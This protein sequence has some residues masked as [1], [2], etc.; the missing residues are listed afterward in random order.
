MEDD[1][2]SKRFVEPSIIGAIRVPVSRMCYE[3]FCVLRATTKRLVRRVA[4]YKALPNEELRGGR[5]K[6]LFVA[7]SS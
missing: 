5:F 1:N 2:R 4:N 7:G 6:V 3:A